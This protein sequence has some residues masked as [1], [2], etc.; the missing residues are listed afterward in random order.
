MTFDNIPLNFGR[1]GDE[2]AWHLSAAPQV[3]SVI[4]IGSYSRGD[5]TEYSDLDLVIVSASSLPRSSFYS[6][7]PLRLRTRELSLLPYPWD[8]FKDLY[9]EGALFMAHVVTE[10]KVLYDDGYFAT[11]T[12][13]P[14]KVSVNS[15]LLQW[16]MLKHRVELFDDM[17]IY[18]RVFVDCLSHLYS[19]LK[20]VAIIALALGGELEFNKSRALE[21][22]V[23]K[24]PKLRRDI[25]E[26]RRL[27]SFHLI[28]HKSAPV[29]EPFVPLKCRK[30]T[31]T[32]V[33]RL[34]RVIAT[35]EE[36]EIENKN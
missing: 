32:Y 31:E 29:V 3:R 12:R 1:L 13:I 15:L 14:F 20:N 23:S 36:N 26:L 9:Y 10:G 27:Q 19:I 18:G 17:S 8:V 4:L 25:T 24:Y 35:V 7:L 30:L 16:R 11:L 6:L 2:V 5:N 22:F 33:D 21:T 34:K 28:W